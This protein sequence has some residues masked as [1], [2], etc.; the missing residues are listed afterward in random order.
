MRMNHN[1]LLQKETL[2]AVVKILQA[3]RC[4]L[5]IYFTRNVF[6]FALL[7]PTCGGGP[8]VFVCIYLSRARC[9]DAGRRDVHIGERADSSMESAL[10]FQQRAL[11]ELRRLLSHLA[12]LDTQLSGGRAQCTKLWCLP[13]LCPCNFFASK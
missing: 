1:A 12:R 3:A 6:C 13:D 11:S 10:N 2:T 9:F 7:L 4:A 8:C 5:E